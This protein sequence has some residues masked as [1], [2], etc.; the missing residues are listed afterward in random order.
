M[1]KYATG[2]TNAVCKDSS[3]ISKLLKRKWL[4]QR[5]EPTTQPILITERPSSCHDLQGL[6]FS[7]PEE[8]PLNVD[9]RRVF[10]VI[11]DDLLH[12]LM[13]GNKLR[14]LDA[15]LPLLQSSSVTDVITCGGCQSAHTAALAVACAESGLHAHLLLRGE[16]LSVPTGYNLIS[17]IFGKVI[18]VSRSEYADR[19]SMLMKYAQAVAGEGVIA[20]MKDIHVC[21]DTSFRQSQSISLGNL[22]K[23]VAIVK[24]GAS[25][26]I[27]LLGLIRLVGYLSQPNY[28]GRDGKLQLVIDSGT[29]TTAIGVALGILILR[30]PWK[31]LG[32]MLL[33]RPE[34]FKKLEKK[35][36]D[37]F[38]TMWHQDADC[39]IKEDGLEDCLEWVCR[40]R[41]RKFGNVLE[42]EIQS[43]RKIARETGILLDPVYTLAAWEV[44]SNMVTA[45]HEEVVMLHTGGTMGLFGLAQRYPSEF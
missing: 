39:A 22:P 4:L 34:E 23:K 35:L 19:D 14:K 1:D 20:Q 27:A 26:A 5:P 3:F 2:W 32:V 40:P 29:G 18:H 7:C 10:H 21:C 15:L 41:P 6:Q 8:T 25:D 11:R 36:L 13:G 9:S 44:S 33:E 38:N 45:G 42:G 37:D 28:F 16:R 43:C 24:E 17:G 30:L 12:P 31:V